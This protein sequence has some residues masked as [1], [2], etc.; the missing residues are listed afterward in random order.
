[1]T[2]YAVP[3]ATDHRTPSIVLAMHLWGVDD[4]MRRCADRFARAGFAVAVPDLYEDFGAPEPHKDADPREF[5]PFA[6]RLSFEIVDPKIRT[7]A[8][9]LRERFP[10][11]ATAIAGFCMGGIMALRRSNGYGDIFS[12]AAVWYGSLK[13]VDGK[14]IDIPLVASFGA[15]DEGIPLESIEQFQSALQVPHDVK[16][17]AGAGHAF[18]DESRPSYEPAAAQDSWDRTIAFLRAHLFIPD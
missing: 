6:Q 12:A 3:K 16:V 13:D 4:N 10:N 2:Y 15:E 11:T 14:A 1:M 9:W 17:Y 18:C 8:A 7:A 5:I